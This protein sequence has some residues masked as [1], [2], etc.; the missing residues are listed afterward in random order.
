MNGDIGGRAAPIDKAYIDGRLVMDS[1]QDLV[2]RIRE[3]EAEVAEE[4]G[5]Y[6]HLAK[7]V[8]F[9]P[10][11]VMAAYEASCDAIE[12][13]AIERCAQEAEQY[14]REGYPGDF[15]FL[16]RRIRALAKPSTKEGDDNVGH[17]EEV[18]KG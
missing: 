11:D 12:A 2:D 13:A 1:K 18:Q 14:E 10:P 5:A 6:H 15:K 17:G 4:R 3:L 7:L 9:R 8:G 16:I